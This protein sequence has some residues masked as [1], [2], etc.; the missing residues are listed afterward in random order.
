M[1]LFHS[2]F[3]FSKIVLDIRLSPQFLCSAFLGFG[4]L[5]VRVQ[6]YSQQSLAES[7]RKAMLVCVFIVLLYTKL[8]CDYIKIQPSHA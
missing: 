5:F 6:V 3:G 1:A 4:C 2:G 7:L 8:A